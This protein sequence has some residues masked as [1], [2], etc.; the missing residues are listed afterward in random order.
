MMPKKLADQLLSI[1]EAI[2]LTPFHRSWFDRYISP[3]VRRQSNGKLKLK[4]FIHSV[5]EYYKNSAD[6]TKK[7]TMEE[8][9]IAKAARELV[10]VDEYFTIADELVTQLRT[11][12]EGVSALV[13]RDLELRKNIEQAINAAFKRFVARGKEKFA[14][15][16]A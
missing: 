1:D 15:E 16:D 10:E 4:D 7:P 8:I 13:T 5:I 12:L 14:T 2:G 11:E 9:K 3:L 6:K